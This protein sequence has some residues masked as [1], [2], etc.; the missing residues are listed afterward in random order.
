MSRRKVDTIGDLAAGAAAG[1]RNVVLSV[2]SMD[3]AF[4]AALQRLNLS[5]IV[6]TAAPVSTWADGVNN[7]LH[8]GMT[9]SKSIS[10]TPE[11]GAS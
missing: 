10:Y 9:T 2:G 1:R 8:D 11:E 7:C 6:D 5:T 3:G 4:L